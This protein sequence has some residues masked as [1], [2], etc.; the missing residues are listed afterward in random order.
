MMSEG[1]SRLREWRIPSRSSMLSDMRFLGS[2]MNRSVDRLIVERCMQQKLL[3]ISKKHKTSTHIET[4]KRESN[5]A[6]TMLNYPFG[7]SYQL[8]HPHQQHGRYGSYYPRASHHGY[9]PHGMP[10]SFYDEEAEE[11]LAYRR[12]QQ[13]LLQR[14][15]QERQRQ[16]E[17]ARLRKRA[18][19]LE[20][21]RDAEWID[22]NDDLRYRHEIQ[23]RMEEQE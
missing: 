17:A 5:K 7:P 15:R 6:T 4:N 22:H 18:A 23:R 10:V 19:E 3:T 16:L 2:S 11:E 21:Y 20:R 12:Q 8:H 13:Q 1:I 9:G 14:Q